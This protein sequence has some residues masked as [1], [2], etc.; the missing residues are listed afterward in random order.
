MFQRLSLSLALLLVA[1]CRAAE[2][3]VPSER[4]LEDLGLLYDDTLVTESARTVDFNGQALIPRWVHTEKSGGKRS[5]SADAE[6]SNFVFGIN[7]HFTVRMAV[8]YITKRLDRGGA[9]PSLRASGLGDIALLSKFRFYQRTGRAETTEASMLFGLELPT[10]RNGVR[11]R[12][13]RLPAALQPGSGSTDAILGG[14]FT[15]VDGRWLLNADLIAKLN[16]EAD[17]YRF[18][19]TFRADIGGQYRFHPAHYVRFDQFTLNLIGELNASWSGR[20][21]LDG[22]LVADSGGSKVFLTTG[23]QAIFNRNFVI[24]AAVQIPVALQLNDDQLE[25]DFVSIIGLRARF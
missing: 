5:L 25:D 24:E 8:P 12:G 1:G 11:D 17:D 2:T 22:A 14:A 7:E 23:V 9:L 20:D 21:H 18:G 16:T 19:N 4:R 6:V 15:R 13:M 3:H 10:G